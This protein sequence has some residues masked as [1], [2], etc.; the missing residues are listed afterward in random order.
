MQTRREGDH[1]LFSVL[2]VLLLVR[3]LLCQ[4]IVGCLPVLALELRHREEARITQ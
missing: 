1:R 2:L 3:P 4:R